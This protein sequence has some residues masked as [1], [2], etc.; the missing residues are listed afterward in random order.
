[1]KIGILT[2]H[3]SENYGSAFQA[4]ALCRALNIINSENSIEIID[5]QNE[6]QRELYRTFRPFNSPKNTAKNIRSLL[7]ISQLNR[8]SAAFQDFQRLLPLSKKSYNSD[9]ELS[10]AYKDYD[11]LICGSDQIW[12]PQSLDFSMAYFGVGFKCKKVS[13]APSIRDAGIESFEPYREDVSDALAEFKRVSLREKSSIPVLK[14][15][16]SKRIR[17]VC[18]PTLLLTYEEYDKICS[19]NKPKGKYIF[20]YSIDYNEQSVEMVKR[21]SEKLNLPV[22]IIF[23]SN[24]TYSVYFKGFKL[25]KKNAPGDF[26]SLIKNASLVLSTSFH[27]VA[28]SVIYRKPFFAL[29]TRGYTDA[30]IN[31]LLEQINLEDR[32]ID[33]GDYMNSDFGEPVN[34]SE[35]AIEKLKNDSLDYLKECLN[36]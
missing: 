34:Y 12:N 35:E 7:N 9:S 20:Y 28:F 27:G 1:M 32:Y 33:Y 25:V 2:F 36:A 5:Y 18:D 24:K 31:C 17:T 19:Q 23:S 8:R 30:R 11:L 10:E 13:Y 4:Y 6:A 14:E 21:I 29:K 16:C 26:I 15:L 22:Y 3:K